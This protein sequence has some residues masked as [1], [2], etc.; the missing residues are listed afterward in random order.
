MLRVLI[1]EDD[2]LAATYL[3]GVIEDIATAD[4]E[5]RATV[6]ETRE[7]LNEPFDVAFLDIDVTN[8]KTFDIALALQE[9]RIPF[10]FVSS[11][12]RDD[13]PTELRTA[14]FVAKPFL[15]SDIVGAISAVLDKLGEG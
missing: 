14:S 6:S 5:V 8:G 15:R 2:L 7:V 1:V 11:S 4:V 9:K 13:V 12:S 10:I 3:A